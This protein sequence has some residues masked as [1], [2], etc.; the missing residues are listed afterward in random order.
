MSGGNEKA[1]F[2]LTPLHDAYYNHNRQPDNIA[3]G[4]R[5]TTI[6]LF[7]VALL[8]LIIAA[9]NFVNFSMASVPFRIKGLNTRRVVGATRG[10]LIW[11]Q[12]GTTLALVLTAF[13]L[14]AGAMSIAATT[15][16]ASYI[17]GSLRVQ[18]N[19]A[20]LLIGL[21]AATVTALT[22]GIFPARYSTSFNPAMVLK[23]SFSLSARGR[24]LRSVLVGVQYLISFVLIICALFIT[25][26]SSPCR[27]GI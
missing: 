20:V 25:L 11:S 21:G 15:G 27:S 13:V 8:I 17:S 10:S 7:S 9:I 5:S 2:R 4:N 3:K 6:T 24:N 26:H 12:L 18:D 22:A 19:P 14:S 16:I 1:G 23:G